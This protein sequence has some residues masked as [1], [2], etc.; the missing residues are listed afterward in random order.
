MTTRDEILKMLEERRELIRSFGVREIGVFGSFARGDQKETSDV[1][2]LV[3]LMKP[4]YR[5]YM[6]LLEYLE[7]TFGRK[8]DLVMKD[9]IKPLIKNRILRETVYVQGF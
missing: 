1:D 9:S 8:V 4:K 6:G 3:D 2:I 7:T 5:N